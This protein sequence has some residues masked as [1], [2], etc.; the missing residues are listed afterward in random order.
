[1]MHSSENFGDLRC[2]FQKRNIYLDL[3]KRNTVDYLE[4]DD[5]NLTDPLM[6]TIVVLS[7]K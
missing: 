5:R 3:N 4:M 2:L 7:E 1:M 6:I